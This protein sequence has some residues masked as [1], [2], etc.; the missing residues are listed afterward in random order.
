MVSCVYKAV[1]RKCVSGDR[2]YYTAADRKCWIRCDR[3][4]LMC[5]PYSLVQCVCFHSPAI[6]LPVS[7]E[8]PVTTY[9]LPVL[10]GRLDELHR[11]KLC[12]CDHGNQM[13][14]VNDGEGL[15]IRL[16]VEGE[17]WGRGQW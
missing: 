1:D 13:L 3:S 2:K 7:K 11:I 12:L 4:A 17:E 9:T 5:Y 10:C 16:S 6:S 14:M 8:L 15:G